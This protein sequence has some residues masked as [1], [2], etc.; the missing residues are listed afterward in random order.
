MRSHWIIDE[1]IPIFTGEGRNYIGKSINFK[2][3]K[4]ENL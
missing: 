3:T 2:E 4:N 1:E